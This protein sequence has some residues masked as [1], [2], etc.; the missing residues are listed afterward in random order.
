MVAATSAQPSVPVSARRRRLRPYGI[1]LG[2]RRQK[3]GQQRR[4]RRRIKNGGRRR[5]IRRPL[6]VHHSSRK[7]GTEFD[8]YLTAL[9][10]SK[11]KVPSKS[12]N[13]MPFRLLLFQHLINSAVFPDNED[14]AMIEKFLKQRLVAQNLFVLLAVERQCPAASFLHLRLIFLIDPRIFHEAEDLPPYTPYQ[15][16]PFAQTPRTPIYLRE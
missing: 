2:G 9:V 16:S 15:G 14:R 11:W 6:L 3:A 13:P 5:P 7:N 8:I 4:P 1:R 12:P 10:G